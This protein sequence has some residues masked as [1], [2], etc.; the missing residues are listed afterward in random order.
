M[1]QREREVVVIT[2]A[3]GG[4]GRAAAQRFARRGARLGL[5]ARGATGLEAAEREMLR[6]GAEAVAV[7]VDVSDAARV[8]RAATI[9]EERFGPIDIW[10]NNA[11]TTVF[12]PFSRITP[13]E[14]KRVTEVTYLGFVYG[15]MT[16]LRRMTARNRGTI[17]QVGSSVSYRGIPLQAAY[18]GAK[19]AIQGFTESVRTELMHDRSSV[20]ITM[21]LL[22]AVNTP[23]FLWCKN[24]WSK[25]WQPV[26][27]IYQPEVPARAIE[28]AAYHRRREIMVGASTIKALM[29]DKLV[30]GFVDWYLARTG[31]KAQE[32]DASPEPERRSNLWEPV[33]G[34]FGAHG[35]FDDRSRTC[36]PQLSFS[37]MPRW[38]RTALGVSLAA[39]ITMLTRLGRR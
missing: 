33:E 35:P 5:L 31:F 39:A 27:P 22:P 13:E 1:A 17:V 2:G 19:H 10:V 18:S 11:M 3:S 15:T 24:R 9:I 28:Y 6:L 26:P 29:A 37:L 36:S 23:Q 20:R 14:Y 21:V 34:D 38:A 12:G 25:K 4:I 30:P 16:A 7:Q 8:E 32:Y